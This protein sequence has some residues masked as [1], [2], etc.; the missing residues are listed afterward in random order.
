MKKNV[1]LLLLLI[2]SC[3]KTS[4][5][6]IEHIQGYWEIESV[7][8]NGKLIKK[9]SVNQNIDYFQIYSD[10]SGFRKK[11]RADLSGKFTTSNSVI[12]FKILEQNRSFYID[13]KNSNLKEK[14]IKASKN[15]LILR[16]DTGLEYRYKS[17]NRIK[18]DL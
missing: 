18:I 10:F 6:T 3:K 11:L 15:I 17:F 2:F 8:K 9:Y 16:N 12:Y 5:N 1:F 14:I 7:Y 4:E 13:Y